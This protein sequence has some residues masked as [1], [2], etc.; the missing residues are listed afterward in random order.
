MR[1]MSFY[2]VLENWKVSQA[3]DMSKLFAEA[4]S[5]SQPLDRRNVS[6]VTD[7]SQMFIE[8]AL[9]GGSHEQVFVTPNTKLMGV[10]CVCI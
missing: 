3:M 9:F 5:F 8:Q 2:D 6:N 4:V 10:V 7:T 1:A